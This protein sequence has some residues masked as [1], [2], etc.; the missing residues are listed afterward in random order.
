[1]K[2]QCGKCE[3]NLEENRIGKQ[4]YCKACQA[5]Y[6]RNFRIPHSKLTKEQRQ[7]SNARA[8]AN[9][10]Q[11]RGLLVP[12]TCETCGTSDVQKHH[13]DYNKPLEVRWFCR[14]CHLKFHR[15]LALKTPQKRKKEDDHGRS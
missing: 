14:P 13:D 6:A 10:Y 9:V 5:E 15:D 8:M 2:T 12:G 1:M 7:R 11:K 4:R 3:K